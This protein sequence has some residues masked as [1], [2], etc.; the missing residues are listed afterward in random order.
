M[1]ARIVTAVRTVMVVPIREFDFRPWIDAILD[2]GV[3]RRPTPTIGPFLT[4]MP[5]FTTPQ[6]SR[7]KALV[8]TRSSTSGAVADHLAA[9]AD[10]VAVDGQIALDLQQ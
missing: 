7:I 5:A 6:W 1:K 10:L 9:E 3:A 8:I 4:P 2:V